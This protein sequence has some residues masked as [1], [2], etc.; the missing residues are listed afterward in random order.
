MGAI[1][2]TD[3]NATIL[4]TGD[5]A[6]KM[7]QRVINAGEAMVAA[8]E[9]A[10]DPVAI[11]AEAE[12]YGA[13]GVRKVTGQSGTVKV[14]T[15]INAA[16]S[17]ATVAIGSAANESVGGKPRAVFVHSPGVLSTRWK[18]VS[19]EEYW[20]TPESLRGPFRRPPK[21]KDPPGPQLV[22]PVVLATTPGAGKGY[23]FLLE[24]LVKAP[25]R[26]AIKAVR[27]KLAKAATGA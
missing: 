13:K 15:T 10:V 17:S 7:R 20:K 16:T 18:S 26:Q 22:F 2:Y 23:G 24:K 1:R 12:W 6:E 25:T 14:V 5:L 19:E 4:L 9:S 21:F 27:P 11:A 3:G 8:V